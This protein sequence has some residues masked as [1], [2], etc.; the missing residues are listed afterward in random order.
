MPVTSSCPL[1]E[2]PASVWV[3]SSTYGWS[4]GWWSHFEN[5][6]AIKAIATIRMMMTMP[7]KANLSLRKLRQKICPGDRP[8]IFGRDVDTKL[9][10]FFER[11]R[12]DID[13]GHLSPLGINGGSSPGA[14]CSD[15]AELYDGYPFLRLVQSCSSAVAL[16][17]I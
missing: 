5:S 6:G 15:P 16:G 17:R 3:M 9:F 10:F 4:T 14:P 13:L 2:F 1:E 12:L 8:M 7:A 11:Y